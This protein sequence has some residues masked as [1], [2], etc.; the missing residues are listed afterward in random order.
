MQNKCIKMAITIK[1]DSTEEHIITYTHI[2]TDYGGVLFIQTHPGSGKIIFI[3]RGIVDIH[4]R[5]KIC[6]MVIIFVTHNCW[7]NGINIRSLGKWEQAIN[8]LDNRLIQRESS[9][10]LPTLSRASLANSTTY[11]P[12]SRR[13]LSE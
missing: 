7:K 3:N 13:G 5:D 2:N 10:R 11:P 9:R 4:V 8:P 1:F 12:E 6:P